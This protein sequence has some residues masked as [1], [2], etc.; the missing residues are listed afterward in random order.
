MTTNPTAADYLAWLAHYAESVIGH[1]CETLTDEETSPEARDS[2]IAEIDELRLQLRAAAAKFGDCTHYSDG[3]PIFSHTEYAP[4]RS[5]MHLW[6]A[7]A[8]Q[9]SVQSIE[10]DSDEGRVTV[11]VT[12]PSTVTATLSIRPRLA[13]VPDGA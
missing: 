5:F 6:P 7:D 3:R 4:R 8:A 2:A 11:T 12:P 13:I 1:G 10:F 9:A